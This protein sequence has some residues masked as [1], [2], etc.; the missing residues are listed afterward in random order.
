MHL[1][2]TALALSPK[3]EPGESGGNWLPEAESAL[4]REEP[5]GLAPG[6]ME[7]WESGAAS[8]FLG[9]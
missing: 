4:V 2:L 9:L 8:T 5:P 1:L 3:S 6:A 7:S